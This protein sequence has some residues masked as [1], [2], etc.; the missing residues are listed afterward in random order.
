MTTRC[1]WQS[2]HHVHELL[3]G[4]CATQVELWLEQSKERGE[5][6]SHE[7]LTETIAHL[8][9]QNLASGRVDRVY[10]ACQPEP[11]VNMPGLLTNDDAREIPDIESETLRRAESL[12]FLTQYVDRLI[13]YYDLEHR[14]VTKLGASD[15]LAWEQLGKMLR[16]RAYI[17]LTRQG[18]DV[19]RAIAEAPEFAQQACEVIC[20]HAYYYD[21]PF[22]AWANLI[23]KNL[24]LQRYCRSHDIMSRVDLEPLDNDAD[25]GIHTWALLHECLAN[26]HEEDIDNIEEYDWVVDAISRIRS[27]SQRYV[28]TASFYEEVSDD[29]IARQLGKSRNAVYILRHRALQH[30]RRTLDGV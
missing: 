14:L 25:Q 13:R 2:H 3:D 8:L 17:L 18:V 12:H 1:C 20:S 7:N 23:L 24:I 5:V 15:P 9:R 22:A 30:L 6:A 29:E 26:P 11:S 28:L 21:V 27:K 10:R 4:L 16:N 19:N